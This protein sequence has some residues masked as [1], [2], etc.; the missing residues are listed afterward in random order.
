MSSAAALLLAISFFGHGLP[1]HLHGP[2]KAHR[3]VSVQKI[4]GWKLTVRRDTFV[5]AAAC[6]LTR[7]RAAYEQGAVTISLPPATDTAAAV[8]RI[9]GGA[10]RAAAAD[11]MAIASLGLPVWRDDLDNPSGGLVRIPA[12][13][14]TGAG[15]VQIETRLG[16]R[17]WRVPVANLGAA[18]AA[19]KTAGCA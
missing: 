17:V 8:Y 4:G 7:G 5:G 1:L 16:G 18:L 19:A 15:L 3:T 11:Q 6:R 13:R 9:D 14:L 12:A 10:P 2:S